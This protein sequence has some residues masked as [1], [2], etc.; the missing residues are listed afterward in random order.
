MP[1]HWIMD[2][3]SSSINSARSAVNIGE[4]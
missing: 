3:D 2:M 1:V 4:D